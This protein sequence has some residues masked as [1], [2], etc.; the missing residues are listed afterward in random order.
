MPRI[1][2]TYTE[3]MTFKTFLQRFNYLRLTGT[4]GE[5][6]FGF[7]RHLN[8][9]LYRSAK[10]RNLR[11]EIIIRDD[12]CDLGIPGYEIFDKVII[13]HMNPLS[14]EDARN[15]SER[16]FNPEELVC[17]SHNTHLALHYGNDSLLPK[18]FV[19]RQ[20]GDTTLW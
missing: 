6:T 13:H 8:Q 18:P 10:W 12:G 17:V 5:A 2:R 9:M 4:V 16:I 1:K 19:P 3:M 7:D 15:R 14:I 20:P 11:D